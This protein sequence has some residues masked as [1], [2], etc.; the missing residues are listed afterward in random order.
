VA[1]LGGDDGRLSRWD[2]ASDG[3][4]VVRNTMP[5]ATG[6]TVIRAGIGVSGRA[7]ERREPVVLNE[8]QLQT[9]DESPGGEDGVRAAVAAP[10]LHEGRLLGV[11]SINSYAVGRRFTDEDARVL[12]LLAGIGAGLLANLARTAELAEANQ[13]LKQAR[14]EA[15]FQALHDSLTGLP[16]RSLLRD[17]LH[18][19]ILGA[20]R[21]HSNMAL[22]MMDLDRFKDVND[23]L[24][25]QSGDELLQQVAARLHT[26]IRASD[27]VARMGGDEFAVILP[28]AHNA[29]E[30][31]EVAH[32]L[33][34]ALDQP[35]TIDDQPVSI[36]VS[37][38]IALYPAHG[39]DPK[40]LLRHADVAMYAAKRG[41]GGSMV[42]SLQDDANDPGRLAMIGDLRHGIEHGELVLNYQPKISL[43]TGECVQVEALVRWRHPRLGMVA[44][45]EFIPLAEQTGLIKPLTRWVLN[46]ALGQLAAWTLTG[47][48]IPVAVNLSM[49][50]LHDPDLVG[51]VAELLH[52]WAVAAELLKVEVTESAVMSDPRQA[53]QTLSQLRAMGIEIAIDDF[54]TGQSSLSYL[55]QLP[56]QEI[57]LDRTFVREMQINLHDFA[58]V[59]STIELAHT[60]GLSVVAEGV[61]TEETWD[62]L[63]ELGC[64]TAQGYYMCRPRAAAELTTWLAESRWG[65]PSLGTGRP[66]SPRRAA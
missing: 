10:L 2:P 3:L 5:S 48:E 30:A 18:Q 15:Q 8:Y 13:E 46:E 29:A 55:K 28:A 41:G 31:S 4:V 16:N 59:R 39:A 62:M 33:T 24:G 56:V 23:T 66:Q 1:V 14:D 43:S 40:T 49:H 53:L 61:E 51:Q 36:G 32:S 25:H 50:N 60:L 27:T 7:A 20:E 47:Q 17:R 63:A 12:E 6:F 52:T 57:K 11:L 9:R 26:L 35:F 37:V 58:I 44:P 42:Y 34:R 64:D 22:L 38:G 65:R 54:G 21:D 45:D 19:A